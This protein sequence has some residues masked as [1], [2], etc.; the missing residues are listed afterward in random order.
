MKIRNTDRYRDRQG[1]V[2]PLLTHPRMPKNRQGWARTNLGDL[3]STQVSHIGGRDPHICLTCH[4][5]LPGYALA[6]SCHWKWLWDTK[7]PSY[8]VS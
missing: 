7:P 5:V 1:E 2:F 6:G 8:E 3:N 4:E